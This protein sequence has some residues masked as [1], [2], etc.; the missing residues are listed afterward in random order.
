LLNLATEI[1]KAA[2]APQR[3]DSVIVPSDG[4]HMEAVAGA[5]ILDLTKDTGAA[6]SNLEMEGHITFSG[7][8]KS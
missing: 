5:C 8:K 1:G 2:V 6:Q 4:V 7:P 3:T